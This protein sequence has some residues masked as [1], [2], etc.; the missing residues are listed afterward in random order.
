MS[1][2]HVCPKC[3]G[4][5]KYP[6]TESYQCP[7]CK[8]DLF[9]STVSDSEWNKLSQVEKSNI[10]DLLY[11]KEEIEKRRKAK[12]ESIKNDGDIN[13]ARIKY[14]S[15]INSF[16]SQEGSNGSYIN[17]VYYS[18]L[19]VYVDGTAEIV[20]G[21]KDTITPLLSFLRTPVDELQD[22]KQLFTS[23]VR[24]IINC[25]Q[26]LLKNLHTKGIF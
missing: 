23:E 1:Y 26:V 22:I 10:R 3:K 6:S 17:Y 20:E 9:S 4:V 12:Q 8:V 15:I 21:K 19:V 11:S 2:I 18:I 7:D 5:F 24:T 13:R 14:T 16:V 25:H